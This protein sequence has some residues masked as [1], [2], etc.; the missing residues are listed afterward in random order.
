MKKIYLNPLE[1]DWNLALLYTIPLYRRIYW[2][3]R[4]GAIFSN[5]VGGAAPCVIEE[6]Q[7]HYV[8]SDPL[9]HYPHL[10]FIYIALVVAVQ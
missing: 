6:E 4:H 9:L 3:L 5:P 2:N 8:T 10:F 7:E 1:G